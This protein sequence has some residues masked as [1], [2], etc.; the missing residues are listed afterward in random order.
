MPRYLELDHDPEEIYIADWRSPAGQ[1]HATVARGGC[2]YVRMGPVLA[3]PFAEVDDAN[4]WLKSR[5]YV[6]DVGVRLKN[7]V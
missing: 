3:G 1:I 6:H 5:G 2:V 4:T 7:Q